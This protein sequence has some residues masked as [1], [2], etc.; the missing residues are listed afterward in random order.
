M[1]SVTLVNLLRHRFELSSGSGSLRN[2]WST[3][4]ACILKGSGV[5]SILQLSRSMTCFK[6]SSSCFDNSKHADS[7]DSIPSVTDAICFL[8]S[9]VRQ[10]FLCFR[11]PPLNPSASE[12]SLLLPIR[13]AYHTRH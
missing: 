4:I 12:H 1:A 3:D 10:S 6:A 5:T 13:K 2:H 7:T 9:S 11:G 8:R